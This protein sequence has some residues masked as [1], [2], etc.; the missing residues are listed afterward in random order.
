MSE[1]PRIRPQNTPEYDPHFEH[2]LDSEE[3][4]TLLKIHPKTLQRMARRGEVPAI[5]IG[6]LW[7][8]QASA[9]NA[10]MQ[11]IIARSYPCRLNLDRRQR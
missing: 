6:K 4:A 5:Q 9:L 3:A 7:R 1:L 11:G 2:L 10:W 8:F